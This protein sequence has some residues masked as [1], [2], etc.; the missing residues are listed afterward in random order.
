MRIENHRVGC[1]LDSSITDSLTSPGGASL[2][3]MNEDE[4][5][6][7]LKQ[8]EQRVNGGL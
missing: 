3:T 8:I 1:T 7:G 2:V 5:R 4:M 6:K